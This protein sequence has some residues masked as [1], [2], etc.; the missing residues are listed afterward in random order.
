MRAYENT[1]CMR[2]V[3]TGITKE[4]IESLILSSTTNMNST[5]ILSITINEE[6][7]SAL[8][9]FNSA[10]MAKNIVELGVIL[11]FGQ[12]IRIEPGVNW[13]PTSSEMMYKKKVT[14]EFGSID[15]FMEALSRNRVLFEEGQHVSFNTPMVTLKVNSKS[16][17]NLSE[18]YKSISVLL[19]QNK[20]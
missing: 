11:F 3:L 6:N 2:D 13:K 16:E 17:Q 5:D 1:I 4:Q 12:A 7:H 14:F 15:E 19:D 8:V 10:Q 20:I 18:A 9:S